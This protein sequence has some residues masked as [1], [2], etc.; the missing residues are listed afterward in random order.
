MT[1]E[2][3]ERAAK[4]MKV[5]R[6]ARSPGMDVVSVKL[7]CSPTYDEIKIAERWAKAFELAQRDGSVFQY[8]EELDKCA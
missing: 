8:A 2:Q 6:L 1:R 4:L 7:N 5:V 3:I